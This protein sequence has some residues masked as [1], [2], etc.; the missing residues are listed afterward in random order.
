MVSTTGTALGDDIMTRSS[1]P[2]SKLQVGR[3]AGGGVKFCQVIKG[4]QNGGKNDKCSNLHAESTSPNP[5]LQMFSGA[6]SCTPPEFQHIKRIDVK[7]QWPARAW[8]L[9]SPLFFLPQLLCTSQELMAF[10]KCQNYA[11]LKYTMFLFPPPRCCLGVQ[12]F[13]TVPLSLTILRNF[14]TDMLMETDWEQL[15]E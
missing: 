2:P 15:T 3:G 10:G 1:W 14:R 7:F 12:M 9:I 5:T 6:Y 8:F 13:P 11:L 4:G